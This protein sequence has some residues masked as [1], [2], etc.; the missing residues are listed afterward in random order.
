VSSG[1]NVAEQ[2]YDKC[3]VGQRES[4]IIHV[5]YSKQTGQQFHGKLDSDSR[6]NWTVGA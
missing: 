5:A 2:P 1:K 4:W 6:A 3:R